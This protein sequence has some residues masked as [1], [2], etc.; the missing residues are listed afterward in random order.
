MIRTKRAYEQPESSDGLRILVDR[1]WPRGIAK[2]DLALDQWM[3]DLAPSN[4]LRKWFG[5][6]PERWS[7]FL[8]KYS[9]E[10]DGKQALWEPLL[11]QSVHSRVTLLY[12]AKDIEHNNAEALKQYL[13]AK[14][15][16]SSRAS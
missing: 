8:A 7:E 9:Q 15:S 2:A 11:K 16:H 12:G 13:R 10:L 5:H 14:Q 1:L 4:E 3:K 6:R